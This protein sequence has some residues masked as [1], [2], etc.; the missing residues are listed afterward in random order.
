MRFAF[1]AITVRTR[2]RAF[3]HPEQLELVTFYLYTSIRTS[4]NFSLRPPG[5]GHTSPP[6][7]GSERSKSFFGCFRPRLRPRIG[8]HFCFNLLSLGVIPAL[9]F[10]LGRL[11]IK[12]N[13][14]LEGQH[15]PQTTYF[16]EN[17]VKIWH[18][19][20]SVLGAAL[21]LSWGLLGLSWKP[22]GAS[23]G[24]LAAIL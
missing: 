7:A 17:V 15:Y 10:P 24:P 18:F 2:K 20:V 4:Q 19:V 6:T 14:I 13:A 16:F 9:V 3:R 22:P 5:P 1:K 12:F 11:V 8:T 21:R 23:G